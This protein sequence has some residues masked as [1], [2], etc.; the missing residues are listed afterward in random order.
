M[1][2][3]GLRG[4]LSS[5]LNRGQKDMLF[6]QPRSLE[7]LRSLGVFTVGGGGVGGEGA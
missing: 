7:K 5:I 4:F 2:R 1:T 6:V 3:T